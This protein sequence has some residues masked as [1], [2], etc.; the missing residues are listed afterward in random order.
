MAGPY[1]LGEMLGSSANGKSRKA[2]DT[3]NQA[4]VA[5]RIFDMHS[6][7]RATFDKRLKFELD[8]IVCAMLESFKNLLKANAVSTT[9]TNTTTATTN[10]FIICCPA[11]FFG[12]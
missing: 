8:S 9:A 11:L 7:I 6:A 5:V 3:R 10:G 12:G 4:E 2:V 1:L